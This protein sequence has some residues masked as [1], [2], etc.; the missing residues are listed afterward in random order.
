ML[1]TGPYTAISAYGSFTIEVDCDGD[2]G[3]LNWDCYNKDNEYNKPITGTIITP[4]S[5]HKV[6]VIYAVLH[7]AVEIN[8]D[9]ILRDLPGATVHQTRVYGEIAVRSEALDDSEQA[10]SVLFNSEGQAVTDGSFSLPLARSVVAMP[11]GSPLVIKATLDLYDA[12]PSQL[13]GGVDHFFQ[14][15]DLKLTLGDYTK[16]VRM[17]NGSEVE[18]KITS[19]EDPC[20]PSGSSAR[21]TSLPPSCSSYTCGGN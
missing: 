20:P 12:P 6:E 13:R 3:E 18:V 4:K 16:K 2:V 17:E 7:D 10:W 21:I 9:F 15:Q 19:R 5:G 14:C 11:L 1:L 8:V